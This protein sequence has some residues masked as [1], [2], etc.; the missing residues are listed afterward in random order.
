MRP[1][2]VAR[3]QNAASNNVTEWPIHRYRRIDQN[4]EQAAQ[5]RKALGNAHEEL[6]RLNSTRSCTARVALPEL[7]FLEWY[8]AFGDRPTANEV[9]LLPRAMFPQLICDF[10]EV[11]LDRI[12]QGCLADAVLHIGIGNAVFE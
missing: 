10:C 11:S 6:E 1:K 4:I 5:D 3:T 7:R 2:Q 12:G 9:R 8:S